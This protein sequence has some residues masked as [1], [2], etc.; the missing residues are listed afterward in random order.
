MISHVL[1]ANMLL[2]Y[3][4]NEDE[5]ERVFADTRSVGFIVGILANAMNSVGSLLLVYLY[6]ISLHCI[7]IN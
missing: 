4:I 1:Q 6:C 3:I 5:S 7:F 2:A